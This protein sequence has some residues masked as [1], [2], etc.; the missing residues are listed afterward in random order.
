MARA[1][2]AFGYGEILYRHQA[3]KWI[4][5]PAIEKPVH[6]AIQ[7]GRVRRICVC[8]QTAVLHPKKALA[9]K[10][11][12]PCWD[13]QPVQKCQDCDCSFK[14]R[15]P[16]AVCVECYNKSFQRYVKGQ[17]CKRCACVFTAKGYREIC[18]GCFE[19][20]ARERNRI[21]QIGLRGV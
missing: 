9:D 10:L 7:N 6:G 5:G 20:K 15:K 19:E 18:L 14:A 2:I 11:C 16:Q 3:E 8:C 21:N 12:G 13:K 17:T 4:K 1:K